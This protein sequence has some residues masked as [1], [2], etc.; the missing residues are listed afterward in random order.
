MIRDFKQHQRITS[1][2]QTIIQ[3]SNNKNLIS[4]RPMKV[5]ILDGETWDAVKALRCLGQISMITTYVLSKNRSSLARFSRYCAGFYHHESQTNED[6]ISEIKKIVL[7]MKI[8][9]ILPV[10][11]TGFEFVSKNNKT[12]S[13]FVV[14]PLLADPELI[15]L[16]H[17]KW[18]FYRL[19]TKLNLPVPPSVFIGKTE[20]QIPDSFDIESLEY[21]VLLKPTTLAGGFGI[22][23]VDNTS[24]LHQAWKDTRI[25]KDCQYM[26]QSFIPGIVYCLGMYSRGGQIIAY[27]VSKTLMTSSKRPYYSARIL[28]YV[29]DDSIIETGRQL[30]SSIKWDG[31]VNIDLI[32]DSRD[33]SVKI[34]DFNPRFW[35]SLLGS[36][37]AGVNFPLLVCLDAMSAQ[38]PDMR[39][40]VTKYIHPATHCKLILS[41]LIGRQRDI[42]VRWRESG[43]KFTRSDPFPEIFEA[44]CSVRKKIRLNSFS[45]DRNK[46]VSK[47]QQCC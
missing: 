25:R 37:I 34:L 3:M 8:D 14:V 19:A 45:N 17:N 35:Q 23:K 6:W 46:E 28:E 36:L 21:P 26:L 2:Q 47:T 7:K 16:T 32:V 15:F 22:V 44:I 41:H 31:I 39:Q 11:L 13:E 9:I 27:T 12:I 24:E 33:G 42:S 40:N 1:Y 43:L 30:A 10:D 20:E 5:L 18:D 38:Y 29:H 4:L